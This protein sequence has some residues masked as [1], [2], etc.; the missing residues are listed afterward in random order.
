ME[1]EGRNTNE[2]EREE[3]RK[4]VGEGREEGIRNP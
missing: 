3:G 1:L 2:E 4:D